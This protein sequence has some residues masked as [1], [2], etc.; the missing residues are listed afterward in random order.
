MKGD[1]T[2]ASSLGSTRGV[3]SLHYEQPGSPGSQMTLYGSGTSTYPYAKATPSAEYWSTAGTPSPPT[4][5]CVQGY[6]TAI[7]VGDTN[8]LYSGGVYSVSTGNTTSSWSNNL[9]LSST[10]E[11][12]DGMIMTVDPKECSNCAIL[13]TVLR[14]DEAGNY[15]CQSCAYTTN[16][17]NGINRASIKCGKPKQAVATVNFIFYIFLEYVLSFFFLPEFF[18]LRSLFLHPFFSNLL[19]FF[20]SFSL[21]L[22]LFSRYF[23]FCSFF[24]LFLDKRCPRKIEK[25]STLSVTEQ[26][27]ASRLTAIVVYSSFYVLNA[28]IFAFVNSRR[29]RDREYYTRKAYISLSFSRRVFEEPVFNARIAGRAIQLYGGEITTASRCV[30][31]VVS[32]TNYTT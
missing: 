30:M 14:R 32:T 13:T 8:I 22:P 23:F 9:S 20:V 24:F 25:E 31:H 21:S 2:L 7:S 29:T 12:L 19:L 27:I 16:K 11:N 4:F 6:Q 15:L 26:T 18:N 3:A 28:P 5:D 1:P 17:M 10:E